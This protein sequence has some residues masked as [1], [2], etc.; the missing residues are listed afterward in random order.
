MGT[1]PAPPDTAVAERVAPPRRLL[2]TGTGPHA[3]ARSDALVLFGA[4]GDLAR[5]KLFSSLYRMQAA[6]TLHVPVVGVARSAWSSD[7]FRTHVERAVLDT[8]PG[9]EPAVV[10]GLIARLSL[11]GGGDYSDP[12]TFARLRAELARWGS[13]HPVFY[14]AIPP[15]AFPTVIEGLG[16]DCATNREEIFG[17]VVTLQP[18]DD[19]AHA[20][21]LA[22]ASDYGLAATV[23]TRDLPRALS[24]SRRQ[25]ARGMVRHRRP[26]LRP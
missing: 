20:L 7:R 4:T 16:P 23:W 3:P 15:S 19:E 10:A 12:A 5:K 9:A 21:A 1:T 14:L 18:F 26:R 22:N 17:P 8:V 6:G 25:G 24:G 13:T 2:Q 11:V